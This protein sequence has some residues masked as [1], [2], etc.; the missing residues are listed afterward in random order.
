MK[1]GEFTA[2]AIL[3]KNPGLYSKLWNSRFRRRF[4]FMDKIKDLFYRGDEYIERWIRLHRR[5]EV[6]ELAMRLWLRKE[7]GSSSL[8]SYVNIFRHLLKS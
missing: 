7:T 2:Q 6:Q 5:P 4:M 3:E 1:S 8:L